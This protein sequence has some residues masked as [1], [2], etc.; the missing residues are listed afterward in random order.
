MDRSYAAGRSYAVWAGDLFR[1]QRAWWDDQGWLTAVDVQ[2]L[3]IG[4]PCG[5]NV[6]FHLEVR[7]AWM[8]NP[9]PAVRDG[10]DDSRDDSLDD[11]PMNNDSLDSR[12]GSAQPRRGG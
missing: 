5:G 10:D 1:V 11:S 6:C 4:V 8:W 12:N 9:Q 3:N 2:L 7:S